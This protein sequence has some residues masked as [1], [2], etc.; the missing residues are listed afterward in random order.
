METQR[1]CRQ[2]WSRH[3]TEGTRASK[4]C[5][6]VT[7]FARKGEEVAKLSTPRSYIRRRGAYMGRVSSSRL[8]L[9]NFGIH[10]AVEAVVLRLRRVLCRSGYCSWSPVR[11]SPRE[12]ETT[13]LYPTKP[14]APT[15]DP[16]EGVPLSQVAVA[17]CHAVYS[18]SMEFIAEVVYS[19]LLG[20]Q[21]LYK[22]LC[23]H[24]ELHG[25]QRALS[26]HKGVWGRPPLPV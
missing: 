15:G 22:R 19:Y 25:Q 8:G 7:R 21:A 6:E 9:A 1:L 13:R 12:M 11:P 2:R 3:G 23:R 26:L 16:G 14:K 20:L 18:D 17:R 10:R 24:F 4:W 5:Q